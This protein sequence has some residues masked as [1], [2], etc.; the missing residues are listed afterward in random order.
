MHSN[1]AKVTLQIEY[2]NYRLRG[3]LVD[4]VRTSSAVFL[5][6]ESDKYV[7]TFNKDSIKYVC[8]RCE[9]NSGNCV[10][11]FWELNQINDVIKRILDN[12]LY[13]DKSE[14]EGLHVGILSKD[15]IY[16]VESTE[17]VFI[18][19]FTCRKERKDTDSKIYKYKPVNNNNRA[20][21]YNNNQWKKLPAAF[22]TLIK[23]A[24]KDIDYEYNR[25]Q[26]GYAA[27]KRGGERVQETT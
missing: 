8:A 20:A 13:L 15:N 14:V 1:K 19:E 22:G 25:K 2:S 10:F 16:T 5:V 17:G 4:I 23:E 9:Y 21:K 6:I 26:A 27:N 11:I 7:Y 12:D 18:Q 3:V 24:F